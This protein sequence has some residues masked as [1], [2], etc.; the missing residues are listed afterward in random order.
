MIRRL[1]QCPVAMYN[2]VTCAHVEQ[3]SIS[4]VD[5]KIFLNMFVQ[6]SDIFDHRFCDLRTVGNQKSFGDKDIA[7]ISPIDVTLY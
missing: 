4:V 7:L 5:H 1:N 6:L 2:V 3:K